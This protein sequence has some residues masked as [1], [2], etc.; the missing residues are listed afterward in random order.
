[1]KYVFDPVVAFVFA[2]I[3]LVFAFIGDKKRIGFGWTFFFVFF[4]I[5]PGIIFLILSPPKKKL[6]PDNPKDKIWNLIL[7]NLFLLSGLFSLYTTFFS[8]DE[9]TQ[10]S[11]EESTVYKILFG[12]YFIG[13]GVYLLNRS[14]R[15]RMMYDKYQRGELKDEAFDPT[16]YTPPDLDTIDD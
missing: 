6:P 11:L 16:N 9:A 5:V 13:F 1:M 12:I 4:W 8:N 7:G 15:N 14:K 10:G 2:I 3:A